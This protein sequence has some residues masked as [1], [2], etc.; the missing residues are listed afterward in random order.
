MLNGR[1]RNE[2]RKVFCA[3]LVLSLILPGPAATELK[4]I[5][6]DAKTG[7]VI[8]TEIEK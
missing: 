2:I 6:V 1:G 3:F 4:E 5:H 8:K 7:A